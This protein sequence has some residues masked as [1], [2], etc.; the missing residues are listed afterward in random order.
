[1]LKAIGC[2][3]IYLK[4]VKIGGVSL[5]DTLPLGKYRKLTSCELKNLYK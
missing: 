3:V 4:R 5:D 1:M 2:Y